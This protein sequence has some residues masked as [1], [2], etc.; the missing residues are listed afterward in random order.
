[1]EG[2]RRTPE[3]NGIEIIT[4]KGW[5]YPALVD[6]YRKAEATARKESVPVLVHVTELTQPQGHSTSG[7]HTRYKSPERLQWES[8]FDCNVKMRQWITESGIA[9]DD[10]LKTLEDK[11]VKYV[12]DEKNAAWKP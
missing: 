9:T 10:E 3:K 8:E 5:D 2:F 4:V 6:A 7:S 12:R 1:M 11:A